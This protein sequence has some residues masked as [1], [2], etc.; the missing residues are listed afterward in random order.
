M[1]HAAAWLRLSLTPGIPGA[2][3]RRLAD[4]PAGLAALLEAGAAE[5]TAL[6]VPAEPA[7]ALT[8]TAPDWLP[9]ALDWLAEPG[10]QL[11]TLA[12]PD[13]PPLLKQLQDAPA[14]LFL[15]GRRE[16]LAEPHFAIVGSRNPTGPG[17]D[18]ARAFAEYLA[19]CGLVICSGLASGIDAA[20]HAG[21]LRAGAPTTAVL[22]CGPDRAYPAANAALAQRIAEEGLVISEYLPGTRP[23]RE[24][25]PRRNRIISGLSL[26]VLVVEA[27]RRSGSLI[28]ARLAGDQGRE[29]FAIPGSIHNP[30]ARGCHQLIRQGA[31]L[32]ETAAD[33][34]VEIGP[35]AG[36]ALAQPEADA[37][38][39][40]A[41]GDR[42]ERTDGDYARLLEAMGHDPC[43]VDSLAARTG[44]T[45]AEVSSMMLILELQ[46]DVESLP[47]GRFARKTTR[48]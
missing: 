41:P 21:A 3:A 35:L 12:D 14:A 32:V 7:R 19:G 37:G 6:G 31:A 16:L 11:L 20:A 26:G 42:A 33:I 44:L 23:L 36:I 28:T 45:A 38:R 43:G 15:R 13:Y 10:H 46:G 48:S 1:N 47:G 17:R 29:V 34:L 8:G 9:G 4:Q 5:L 39:G 18:N 22:G 25:F 27:A 40:D 30:L 2:V 24:H